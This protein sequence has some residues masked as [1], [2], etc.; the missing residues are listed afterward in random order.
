MSVIYLDSPVSDDQRRKQLFNGDLFVYSPS[1]SSLALCQFAKELLIEAFKGADPIT[2]QHHFSKEDYLAI[3]SEVKPRFINHPH[4]KELVVNILKEMGC[5]PE[6]TH[7]DVPRMRISTSDQYLTRGIAYTFD[8]HR[9]TWF[10]A[11]LNQLN[12]WMPIFDIEAENCLAFHPD[13]W[14]RHIENGSK[15]YNCYEWYEK[16]R[17]IAEWKIPDTRQRPQPLEPVDLS[18]QI[19]LISKV[20]GIILFSGAHLHSSVPNTSG[21]TRFSIDFRTVHIQDVAEQTG[22]PNIDNYCTGTLMRD[23]IRCTNY[24]HIPAELV[25]LYENGT[26]V[27]LPSL[28]VNGLEPA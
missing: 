13:Y 26:P 3:L 27:Q 6:K 15:G 18:N 7:F 21:K 24:A 23:F 14:D 19:R 1:A 25:A 10:S 12:W 17:Q 8:P 9:D 20:G 28:P 16:A 11:P 22:A 4:S 2:A 5:D